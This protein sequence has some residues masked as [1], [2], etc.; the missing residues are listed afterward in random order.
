MLKEP[1]TCRGPQALRRGLAILALLKR[2]APEGVGATQIAHHTGIQR[3]TVHRLLD[4][5][6]D[7]GLVEKGE[8]GKRYLAQSSSSLSSSLS[9]DIDTDV[10]RELIINAIPAM[11]RLAQTF[12][13]TVYLV[14]RDKA[15][16]VSLYREIGN[17]PVQVIGS[18]PGN[19]Y[20]LGIGSAGL[21]LLAALPEN[22][23]KSIVM[24]NAKKLENYEGLSAT[25]LLRLRATAIERGYAAMQ[26]AVVKRAL[27]VGCAMP[28]TAGHP[29][30]A[31]SVSSVIE[32]MPAKR[33]A[34]I[35]SAIKKELEPLSTRPF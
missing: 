1:T 17:Y 7:S 8:D 11:R 30:I 15:E 18:Y 14:A 26:N 23:A 29:F 33:Q 27:G 2:I 28:N 16:S 31:I 5:L 13:D 4:A 12:G 20:P 25:V 22:E 21:A 3:P 32:R 9:F 6:E 35:A 24:S 34:E 19:R 10:P